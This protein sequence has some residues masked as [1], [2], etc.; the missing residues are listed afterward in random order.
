MND[1]NLDKFFS[2]LVVFPLIEITNTY[3][4][5]YCLFLSI[6]GSHGTIVENFTSATMFP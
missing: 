4:L 3:I 1:K 2:N 6:C 5:C